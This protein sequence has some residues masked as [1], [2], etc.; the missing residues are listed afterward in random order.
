MNDL[1]RQ[2]AE[3]GDWDYSWSLYAVFQDIDSG[4]LFS[5]TDSGCSCYSPYEFE[6]DLDWTPLNSIHDAIKEARTWTSAGSKDI[7]DFVATLMRLDL[8]PKG[9]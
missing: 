7:E 5:T 9:H 3:V 2:I 8:R 6:A 1:K 4:Q